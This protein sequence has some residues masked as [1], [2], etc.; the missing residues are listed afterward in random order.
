[1]RWRAEQRPGARGGRDK[2]KE[3]AGKIRAGEEVDKHRDEEKILGDGWRWRR[4]Q[5]NQR[6]RDNV[7]RR[8]K[9]LLFF[10]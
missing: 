8:K 1:L 5:E 7:V 2:E 9:Y 10:K 3:S 4:A 6:E